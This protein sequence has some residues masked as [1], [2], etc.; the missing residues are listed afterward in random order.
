MIKILLFLIYYI[1]IY[2]ILFCTKLLYYYNT[3]KNININSGFFNSIC[4][5]E[6]K[7][8]FVFY[9]IIGLI[10]LP[11]LLFF[12]FLLY[13]IRTGKSSLEYPEDYKKTR[14]KIIDYLII[15]FIP[16][17]IMGSTPFSIYFWIYVI[18]FFVMVVLFIRLDAVYLNPI[19]ILLGFNIFTDENENKYYLTRNSLAKLKMAKTSEDYLSVVRITSNFYYIKK[20][21][22]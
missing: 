18:I 14:D 12:I 20:Y 15:Y 6:Q 3:D 10:V 1:P 7:D 19:L 2:F 13:K 22:I 9:L 5:F 17:S 11:I 21:K 8:T 16:F 4:V